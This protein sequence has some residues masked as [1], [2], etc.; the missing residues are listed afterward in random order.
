MDQY[1][2][3]IDIGYTYSRYVVWDGNDFVDSERELTHRP[4][5]TTG[6]DGDR[7]QQIWV[8]QLTDKLHEWK[9][10]WPLIS[11]VGLS[12]P[13][14][15]DRNGAIARMNSIW[16]TSGCD[17][18]KQALAGALAMPVTVLNDLSAAA[19]RYGN[20]TRFG[21]ATSVMVVSVSSGIGAKIYD[22][23]AGRLVLE[24]SGRNGEIGLVKVDESPHAPVTGDGQL[25]GILGHYAS[26]SSFA[27]LLRTVAQDEAERSR[28]EESALA[29]ILAE[30]GQNLFSADRLLVNE[31]AVKAMLL[32]DAFCI[33][34]LSR[35]VKHL[36]NV[37]H[38]GILFNAPDAI[39][40]VGGFARS[41][42]ALYIDTLHAH[43]APLL[44]LI[45]TSE[46]VRQMIHLG[47]NDDLDN[48]WGLV[49]QMERSE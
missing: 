35:S 47:E 6:Y 5:V 49:I 21:E 23:E 28:Y 39:V 22:R 26:G 24:R 2:L 48:L 17:L 38:I 18:P 20:S 19:V 27:R 15:V 25:V 7:C 37:L 14:V 30:L 32:G 46:E 44:T 3:C 1:W 43:L 10:K 8:S 41:I 31:S 4:K 12:F 29:S 45:Y 34:V 40:L 16:G 13:G 33:D 9:R 42:G 11:R 36:A